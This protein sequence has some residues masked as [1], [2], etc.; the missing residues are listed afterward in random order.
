MLHGV[1]EA[2]VGATPVQTV[3]A[4]AGTFSVDTKVRVSLHHFH[5]LSMSFDQNVV[6]EFDSVFSS[7][8]FEDG[9]ADG[10]GLLLF[11]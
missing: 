9:R 4:L 11:F 3:S 5:E 8:A 7:S 10:V 2:V 1:I 6:V